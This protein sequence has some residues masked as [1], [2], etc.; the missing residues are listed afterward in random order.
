MI[1]LTET[2]SHSSFVIEYDTKHMELDE[3]LN[4][5]SLIPFKCHSSVFLFF[6]KE[7]PSW[8]SLHIIDYTPSILVRILLWISSGSGALVMTL[9][10]D[11]EK[12]KCQDATSN[13]SVMTSKL[14]HRFLIPLKKYQLTC[15][16]NDLL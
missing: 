15:T 12:K 3:E 6:F 16:A 7:S 13:F 9:C 2:F 1:L 11:E 14:N 4:L 10:L 8:Y 5:S